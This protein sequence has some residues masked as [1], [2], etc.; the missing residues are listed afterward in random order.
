MDGVR[1]GADR[2][3]VKAKGREEAWPRWRSMRRTVPWR[4]LTHVE[5]EKRM[6]GSFLPRCA[7]VSVTSVRM[8]V[9]LAGLV[10][11]SRT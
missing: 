6:G 4:A 1:L 8:H 7:C 10:R 2:A 9:T 11:V 3:R 5:N